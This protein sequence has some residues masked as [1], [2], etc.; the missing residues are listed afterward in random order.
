MTTK[1]RLCQLPKVLQKGRAERA[2][3]N[4]MVS[5][6]IAE[7]KVTLRINV[8]SL[9]K[10][11]KRKGSANAAIESDLESNEAFAMDA[12]SEYNVPELESVTNSMESYEG[13]DDPD[14]D[15]GD[16]FLEM[17]EKE[18]VDKGLNQ[19]ENGLVMAAELN[20]GNLPIRAEVYNSRCTKHISLYREDLENFTEIPP[21]P[22]CTVNKQSFSAT[23]DMHRVMWMVQ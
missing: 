13:F 10:H 11:Q 3:E 2:I 21:H 22:F 9:Q 20:P 23:S 8:L 6:G 19:I 18:E 7:R 17:E 1:M 12:D 4:P 16:W 5:V 14:V 15:K